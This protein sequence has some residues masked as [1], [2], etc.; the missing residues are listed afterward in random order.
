[1]RTAQCPICLRYRGLLTCDAFPQGIPEDIL[2]GQF[3]HTKAKAS[4]QTFEPMVSMTVQKSLD[5]A[6]EAEVK[7]EAEGGFYDYTQPIAE[8]EEVRYERVKELARSRGYKDADFDEGGA[9]YGW[10]TNEIL[11]LLRDVHPVGGA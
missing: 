9:F 4:E 11:D 7:G 8:A 3:D 10:S 2:T 6:G 5:L 1:M